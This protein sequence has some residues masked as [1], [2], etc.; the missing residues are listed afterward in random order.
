M[1]LCA[2]GQRRRRALFPAP[3]RCRG[4]HRQR[5]GRWRGARNAAAGGHYLAGARARAQRAGPAFDCRQ[6]GCG[7]GRG[8][9]GR[10][11]MRV[12]AAATARIERLLYTGRPARRHAYLGVVVVMPHVLVRGSHQSP[13]NLVLFSL[14]PCRPVSSDRPGALLLRS[15]PRKLLCDGEVALVVIPAKGA[16]SGGFPLPG[17]AAG[18]FVP[19][20]AC[21]RLDGLFRGA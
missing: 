9:S 1:G 14:L 13:Q 6:V 5:H 12:T 18:A 2:R 16:A 11:R 3:C 17:S 8:A 21:Q 7:V 19:K 4:V 15:A 20:G 10:A